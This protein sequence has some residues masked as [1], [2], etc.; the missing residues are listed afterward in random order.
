MINTCEDYKHSLISKTFIIYLF[1][2]ILSGIVM[3]PIMELLSQSLP[4][5]LNLLVTQVFG[6]CVFYFIDRRIFN[7]T[8]T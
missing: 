1:R 6:A 5:W 2:W 4:L 8:R 7:D 3:I